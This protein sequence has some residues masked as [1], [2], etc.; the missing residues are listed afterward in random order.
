MPH[1]TVEYSANLDGKV[2]MQG[3]CETIRKAML[4]T[5]IFETGAVR[6][7]AIRC[8]AYSIAD[9]QPANAFVDISLRMGEGRS[10]EVRK[11]AGTAISFSA[12]TYLDKLFETPHF[13]LS[14]EVREISSELSWKKNAMHARL[15]DA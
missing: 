1:V 15:R 7:R 3:L 11:T 10:M 5:G 4:A 14:V 2:D 12:G 6:V 8:D 9:A 13:A